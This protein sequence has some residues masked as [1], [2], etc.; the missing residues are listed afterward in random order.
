[1]LKRSEGDDDGDMAQVFSPT[2]HR[3][4]LCALVRYL[5]HNDDEDGAEAILCDDDDEN[6]ENDSH[7]KSNLG[8]SDRPK[9]GGAA[10]AA[11]AEAATTTR[12]GPR[13][14]RRLARLLMEEMTSVDG[15][16]VGGGDVSSNSLHPSLSCIQFT[17]ST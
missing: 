8:G 3:I 2:P 7:G 15:Q 10:A 11:A 4:A 16:G 5:N 9:T 12:L 13:D 6:G 14:R 17:R 1:M